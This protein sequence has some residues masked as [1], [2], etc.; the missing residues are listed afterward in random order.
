MPRLWLALLLVWLLVACSDSPFLVQDPPSK[1]ATRQTDRNAAPSVTLMRPTATATGWALQSSVDAVR[2]AVEGCATTYRF[3]SGDGPQLEEVM[4]RFPS[5]C[6]KAN[7]ENI[8]QLESANRPQS[9]HWLVWD[10]LALYDEHDAP[11]WQ[12]GDNEAPPD[13]SERAFDE[14]QSTLT[15][16]TDFYVGIMPVT[17]FPKELNDG[18]FS[19]IALHFSLTS[20]QAR[21]DLALF[22]DTLFATHA[23]APD[24]NLR[25]FVNP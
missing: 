25:V 8:I 22:L 19:H 18:V 4:L 17:Q 16:K 10:S 24:F 2:V 20:A 12:L 3:R 11:I 15:N 21:S 13:Y 23:Q 7:A 5:R 9:G 1:P 6:F 14:F